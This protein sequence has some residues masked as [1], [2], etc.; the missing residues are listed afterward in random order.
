V[1]VLTGAL[2]LAVAFGVVPVP[3]PLASIL[4]PRPMGVPG[5]LQPELVEIAEHMQLTEE[6]T[7][8][9]IESRPRLADADEVAEACGA[10]FHGCFS[11]SADTRSFDTIVIL[12]PDPSKPATQM[13][14]IAA[15]ELLHAVYVRLDDSER[16]RVDE[17]LATEIQRVPLDDPVHEQ[18]AASVGGD[19]SSLTTELFAYLGTQFM[20][21]GGMAAELEGVYARYFIDRE[22]VVRLSANG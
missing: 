19:E 7:Q 6:G 10:T 16:Q 12:R 21:A 11:G 4:T 15:H 9:F 5:T 17:L 18:I 20:P 1:I 2:V 22:A 14:T 13:V 8:A 3:A